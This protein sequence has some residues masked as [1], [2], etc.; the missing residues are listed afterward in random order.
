ME[1]PPEIWWWYNIT[2]TGRWWNYWP[3]SRRKNVSDN[4]IAPNLRH[5]L[6]GPWWFSCQVRT[7][8]FEWSGSQA[9]WIASVSRLWIPS[10]KNTWGMLSNC[11]CSKWFFHPLPAMMC[12][13]IC[14]A[15]GLA[16]FSSWRAFGF[17]SRMGQ[18]RLWGYMQPFWRCVVCWFWC[19]LLSLLQSPAA[20]I[21]SMALS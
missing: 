10:F 18:G 7:H 16:S 19:R 12:L 11:D 1:N 8:D 20:Q 9:F 17:W 14:F 3:S 5:S 6:T 4:W 13:D 21:S 2:V 15:A